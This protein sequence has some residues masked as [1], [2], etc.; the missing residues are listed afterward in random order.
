M[1]ISLSGKVAL[2][3]GATRGIGKA[4]AL[5][6]AKAG[7]N[8][9]ICGRDEARL[10]G[11]RK[12]VEAL[13]RKCLSVKADVSNPDEVNGMVNKTLDK[14]GKIDILVN[15]AGITRDGLLVRMKD[16]DWRLVLDTNLTG[17]F[18][19]T[20]A[21]SEGMIRA[22]A[23]RIINI[24][25]TIALTGNEGQ[26]NY[27]AAKAGILGLTK[28][29]ARELASRGITC[30]A[31]APGFIETDMTAKV[32]EAVRK[33]VLEQIPAGRFGSVE[34][35]AG[36]VLFLAS[37]AASYITGQVIRVDGGMVMS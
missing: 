27:A 33:H 35:V 29:V 19:M 24:S 1:N 23:G 5:E 25:S 6:L 11:C 28:S 15:N 7:A 16:E 18:W 13:G 9:S 26:A 10:S 12:E 14:F 21:V 4:I 3:T 8:L 36:L 34:Q 31:V 20:R 2:V 32:S 37:D 30:N 22:H 17:V